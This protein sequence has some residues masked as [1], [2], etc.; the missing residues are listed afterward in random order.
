[1]MSSDFVEMCRELRALGAVKVSADN[2]GT[3]S[4]EFVPVTATLVRDRDP[5][6]KEV[7]TP[8]QAKEAERRRELGL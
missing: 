8:E 6:P 3:F 1:M 4:V 2:S 5:P 7:L